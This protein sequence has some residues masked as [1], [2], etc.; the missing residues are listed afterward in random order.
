[1]NVA[2]GSSNGY[3]CNH[4]TLTFHWNN[5]LTVSHFSPANCP[6]VWNLILRYVKSPSSLLLAFFIVLMWK[7]TANPWTGKIIV[8]A[9]RSTKIWICISRLHQKKIKKKSWD[10]PAIDQPPLAKRRLPYGSEISSNRFVLCHYNQHHFL[11]IS[12]NLELA[13]SCGVY[14]D[15]Q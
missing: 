8:W 4:K 13:N 12:L 15:D 5:E 11:K 7:G 9:L 2:S 14:V 6:G 3:H 1:M 10:P